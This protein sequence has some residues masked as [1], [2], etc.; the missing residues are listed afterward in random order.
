MSQKIQIRRGVEAQRASITPDAGELLF[1][2]DNKQLFVGDGATAG[3]LLVG[4]GSFT[5]FVQK[6]AGTQAIA[7]GADSVAVTGLGL[8]SAPSQVLVTVRKATGGLNLFACVRGDSITAA[9]FTA[10]LSAATDAGTY[11]LD[12]V[13]IV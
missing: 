11:A 13:V 9:G 7:A 6:I 10:D 12:W 5:G 3:G 2:T 1:T 8:A 4:G